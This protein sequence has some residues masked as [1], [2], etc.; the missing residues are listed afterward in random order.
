MNRSTVNVRMLPVLVAA[1]VLTLAL[2]PGEVGQTLRHFGDVALD[3]GRSMRDG[4]M[5][6]F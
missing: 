2:L 6:L 3:A 5:R 1:L 4:Y